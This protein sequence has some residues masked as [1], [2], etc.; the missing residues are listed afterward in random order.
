MA[1]WLYQLHQY[2]WAIQENA[3]APKFE[4]TT[5]LCETPDAV[6]VHLYEDVPAWQ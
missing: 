1:L 4:F 6:V 3:G 5:A 2:G